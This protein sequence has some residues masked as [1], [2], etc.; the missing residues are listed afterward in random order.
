[1][2]SRFSRTSRSPVAWLPHLEA[3]PPWTCEAFFSLGLDSATQLRPV[4]DCGG[5]AT[6]LMPSAQQLTEEG[7]RQLRAL[8]ADL[9]RRCPAQAE[10]AARAANLERTLVSAQQECA[11]FGGCAL[12]SEYAYEYDMLG[13]PTPAV[14]PVY[15]AAYEAFLGLPAVAQVMARAEAVLGKLAALLNASS[16]LLGSLL[17]A[18]DA[19]VVSRCAGR[20]LNVPDEL[21]EQLFLAQLDMARLLYANATLGRFQCGRIIAAALEELQRRPCSLLLTSEPQVGC[22]L[23]ALGV[24]VGQTVGF[25]AHL[26]LEL[27]NASAVRATYNGA[28]LALPCADESGLCLL[29][30]LQS[31]VAPL[32]LSEAQW[33]AECGASPGGSAFV[34]WHPQ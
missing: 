14:C 6:A 2:A 26:E 17:V 25:A 23:G 3:T 29:A 16:P 7:A 13:T 8:G 19:L 1:M 22:L 11:G 15:V 24:F 28:L 18:S 21:T 27:W 5:N 10:L 31:L 30:A 20:T 12:S 33:F 32:M 9:L 4:S 34:R